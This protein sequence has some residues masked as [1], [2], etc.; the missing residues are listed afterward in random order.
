VSIGLTS[1]RRVQREI[2]VFFDPT[3]PRLGTSAGILM[4]L[5]GRIDSAR[6]PLKAFTAT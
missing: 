2:A 3:L 1:Q 4:R 6:K 5:A